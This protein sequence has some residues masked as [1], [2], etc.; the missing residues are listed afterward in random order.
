M[1]E[2]SLTL[3][4]RLEFVVFGSVIPETSKS[5]QKVVAYFCHSKT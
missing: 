2:V 4:S 3:R 5:K 1:R